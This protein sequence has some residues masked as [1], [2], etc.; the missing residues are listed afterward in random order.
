MVKMSFLAA[1]MKNYIL[2]L[3]S[4]EQKKAKFWQ[5]LISLDRLHWWMEKH[6]LDIMGIN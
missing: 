6:I 4:T 2:F 5:V 1:V 3:F